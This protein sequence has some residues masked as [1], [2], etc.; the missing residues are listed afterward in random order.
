MK[1]DN[2]LTFFRRL[3]AETEAKWAQLAPND[4]YASI[5]P[6]TKWL[7]GL[8][9]EELHAF[10]KEMGFPFPEP[11]RNFYRTMNGVDR[12]FIYTYEDGS[13]SEDN[14][15]YSYPQDIGR[16]RSMIAWVYEDCGITPAIAKARGISRIFP[17]W[18]HRFMM[19]DE[20]GHPVL[21][22]YGNDIIFYGSTLAALCKK[23]LGSTHGMR[24]H[25]EPTV[26]FWYP[27][28]QKNFKMPKR[29]RRVGVMTPWLRVMKKNVLLQH[30]AMG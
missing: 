23:D 9:E 10:E 11:L 2:S 27:G 22:M 14:R 6:G 7:P 24:Q 30:R 26:R 18:G 29:R 4:P 21:S 5:D 1:P 15:F 28:W 25:G 13:T 17:I 16:I 20:P 19:I 8:S 12:P 3:K